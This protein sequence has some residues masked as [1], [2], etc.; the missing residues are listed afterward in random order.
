MFENSIVTRYLS[1]DSS[2]N[3]I[4]IL[5]QTKE[6][7][8]IIPDD[9]IPITQDHNTSFS[10]QNNYVFNRPSPPVPTTFQKIYTNL[11]RMETI[12]NSNF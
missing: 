11:R 3:T 10:I 8:E 6:T 9:A 7:L 4:N 1:K 5:P 12:F 2:T